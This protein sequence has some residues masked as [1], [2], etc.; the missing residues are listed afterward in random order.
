MSLA[1]WVKRF[2]DAGYRRV[3]VDDV[4]GYAVSTMWI[5]VDP[6]RIPAFESRPMIFE[7]LVTGE[8]AFDS[9]CR[10]YASLDDAI[11]GHA[12]VVEFLAESM[13]ATVN[14]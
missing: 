10:R 2:N 9:W 6:Q 7:T 3:A 11:A 13:P 12:A 14:A 8:G 1:S 5:G 4:A